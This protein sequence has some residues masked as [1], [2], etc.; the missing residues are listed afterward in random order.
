MSTTMA[1]KK[2]NLKLLVDTTSNKVLFAEAGKE[3]VD[4]FFGL[5]ALPIG[6][7]VNLLTKKCMIGSLG[8]LYWSLESMSDTY[9]QSGR[10]KASLLN[11]VVASSA[12]PNTLL[13]EGGSSS[14]A[15]KRWYNCGNSGYSSCSRQYYTDVNGT[16]CPS[17]RYQMTK[18]LNYVGNSSN[19]EMD[20]SGGIV[21]E[22]VTYMVMDDLAVMPMSTISSITLL[23]KFNIKDVGSLQERVVEL[24]MDEGLKLLRASLR[25]KSVLT[26]VF[27]VGEK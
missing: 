18:E 5:L 22:V 15:P 13:L 8:E 21:K 14:C 16:Q 9:I 3:V 1:T 11:P 23:N 10:N 25:S 20:E 26:D 4:F 17:C 27:L 6:S 19:V 7:V 12:R 2:H 24:G